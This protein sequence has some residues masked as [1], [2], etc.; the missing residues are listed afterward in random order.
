MTAPT[1]DIDTVTGIIGE[2]A[3]AEIMPLFQRLEAGHIKEKTG[4]R[5]LVT[6]ADIA[7]ERELSRRLT[8]LLPGSQVVG[9][10][11]V[12]ADS[13][14]LERLSGDAPV[15]VVD[16]L[17]GTL[18]FT[19]GRKEFTVIVALVRGGETVA[20]WIHEPIGGATVAG[21][22]GQG[23]WE[24]GARLSVAAPAPLGEMT[25]VLYIGPRRAP[26]LYDRMM[27]IGDRLGP[28]SMTR[29]AGA[30]YLALARGTAHY[31][32]FTRLLP[33]DHAAGCLIHREA[34]GHGALFDGTPYRPVQ[35]AG[36]ILLAPDEPTWH[37]L[38]TLFTGPAEAL[39]FTN[40]S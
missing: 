39:G 24:R 29:C 15:W 16:P 21:E 18:N 35:S 26:D 32:F 25:A 19:E 10:E 28:K 33:W 6:A 36:P 12:A 31:A 7:A 38:H 13:A 37:I 2:V 20:G 9:E 17:D 8:D 3:E 5:D 14:V 27:A 30:E 40:R 11:A 4:P 23:A 1:L 22:A 34:G